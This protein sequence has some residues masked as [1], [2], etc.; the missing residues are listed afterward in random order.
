MRYFIDLS[1][2]G[3]LYHGWQNQPNALS[4]QECVEK[5]LSVLLHTAIKV[6]GAGR[7]DA[8]VHARSYTA[9]FD[10]DL[11]IE[12]TLNFAY[13]MNALLPRDISFHAIYQVMPEAHARFSAVSRT[14]E[15][16][17]CN[18][19][20]PFFTE[21]SWYYPM[22]LN[23]GTMNAACEI[24]KGYN[25]FTSF[26]KL[27]SDVKNNICSIH[28]AYWKEQKTTLIFTIK[29][30]RFLRNMVRSI[31][32]TMIDAGRGKITLNDFRTIIEDKNRNLAGLSVP[33]QGLVLTD[34]Q[35]PDE[36]K[37][38]LRIS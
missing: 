31:V 22:A 35:Y 23:T 11:P 21:F 32:G 28:E 29:A 6:T 34:I 37:S 27:H 10:T 16:T 4:V 19:K 15:Y 14:Y 7:T 17:I 25:D 5:A 8:G 12:N 18:V 1:F 33:A 38:N 36:I 9:H 26:S 3:T 20:D 24:L 2:K 13:Q 30:N